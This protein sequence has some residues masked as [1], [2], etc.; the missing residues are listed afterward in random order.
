[1]VTTISKKVQMAKR[2]K[3]DK[4]G[5]SNL[6][7]HS[8]RKNKDIE[9]VSLRC[10]ERPELLSFLKLAGLLFEFLIDP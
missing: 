4:R 2:I 10:L 8:I 1:M 6:I 7:K 9:E 5:K 3:I